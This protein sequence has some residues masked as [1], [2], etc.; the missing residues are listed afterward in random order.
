MK[1]EFLDHRVS[2]QFTCQFTHPRQEGLVGRSPQFHLETLPLANA[3]HLAES[4][5][6]AGPQDRFTLG[7]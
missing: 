2:E 5:P 6:L 3:K 4:E 1:R 7:S